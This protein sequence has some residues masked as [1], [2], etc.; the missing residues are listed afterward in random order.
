M[1]AGGWH[2]SAGLMVT[3]LGFQPGKD[4]SQ[5]GLHWIDLTLNHCQPVKL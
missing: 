5:D 4:S 2:V 3:L 1:L